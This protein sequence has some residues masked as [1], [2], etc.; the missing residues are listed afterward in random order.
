[1]VCGRGGAVAD[2]D[3]DSKPLASVFFAKDA[4]TLTSMFGYDKKQ[5]A[6]PADS[7]DVD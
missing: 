4:R 6:D 1:M 2:D 5:A 7:A 3:D